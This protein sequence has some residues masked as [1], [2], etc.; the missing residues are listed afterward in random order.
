LSLTIDAFDGLRATPEPLLADGHPLGRSAEA[1]ARAAE[2]RDSAS[3][4]RVPLQNRSRGT[5]VPLR[6]NRGVHS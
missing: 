2:L 1:K 4:R 6:T 5:H 3:A